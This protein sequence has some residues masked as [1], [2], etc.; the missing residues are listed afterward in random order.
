MVFAFLCLCLI[1]ASAAQPAEQAEAVDIPLPSYLEEL[2]AG[3][4]SAADS[5]LDGDIGGLWDRLYER[6][7][8]AAGEPLRLALRTVGLLLL[9]S[10]V[11]VMLAEKSEY[12][13]APQLDTVIT[14]GLFLLVCPPVLELLSLLEETIWQCRSFITAFIPCYGAVLTAAGYPARAAVFTG[15]FLTA[16]AGCAQLICQVFLPLSR[17]FLAL[18]LASGLN[19]QPDLSGVSEMAL[20]L[21]RKL[22]GACAALFS[23]VLCLQNV[24]AGAGDTL[25]KKAGKMLVGS[26]VP[27]IGRAV[28]DAMGAVYASLDVVR[29]TVGIAG[30]CAAAGLFLPAAVQCG[31]YWLALQICMAAARLFEAQQCERALRGLSDCFELYLAVLCFFAVLILVAAALMMGAGG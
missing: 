20:R 26:T 2:L 28:S 14:A 3:Q 7:K 16:A 15:F 11:R 31:L 19:D 9:G 10:F 4:K 1:P 21:S 5:L 29:S 17:V 23:T 6:I 25:A 8:E 30:I 27:V 12:S 13:V 22:L 24:A 18:S